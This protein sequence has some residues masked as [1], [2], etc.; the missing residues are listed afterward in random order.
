MRADEA[1]N[2]VE[3]FIDEALLVGVDEIKIVHGKGHGVLREIVR[4]VTKGHPGIAS[5][6]DEHADRGGA[7]ISIIKLQ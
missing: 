1:M 2:R 7:G 4:N 5:V 3:S 6:E